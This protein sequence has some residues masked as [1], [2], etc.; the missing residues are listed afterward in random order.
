MSSKPL[1]EFAAPR[2]EPIS[3]GG[4]RPL[5]SV[6]VPVYNR[7]KYL[8]QALESVLS[9]GYGRDQMQIE[10]VDDCSENSEIEAIVKELCCSRIFFYRQRQ[11]DQIGIHA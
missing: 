3:D 10:V 6:M 1:T 4:H 5:W 2:V 11:R 7:A 9:Q 8:R